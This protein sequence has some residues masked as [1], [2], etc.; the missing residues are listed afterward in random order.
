MWCLTDLDDKSFEDTK[1][2]LSNHC[3]VD[4]GHRHSDGT[5]EVGFWASYPGTIM[6]PVAPVFVPAAVARSSF[7]E[8]I[9]Y[10]E[11]LLEVW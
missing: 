2:F 6:S 11:Q 8:N 10:G 5:Y 1:L 4:R 7:R 3:V 9:V